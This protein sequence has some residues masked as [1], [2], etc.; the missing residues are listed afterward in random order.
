MRQDIYKRDVVGGMNHRTKFSERIGD[1][2]R[3]MTDLVLLRNVVNMDDIFSTQENKGRA[4][5]G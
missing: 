4:V 5:F 2:H 3:E 1:D